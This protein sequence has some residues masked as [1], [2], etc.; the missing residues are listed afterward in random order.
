MMKENTKDTVDQ[1]TPPVEHVTEEVNDEQ[2]VEVREE[3]EENASTSPVR[4]A[5]SV[6]SV[7]TKKASYTSS[8]TKDN[9]NNALPMI[10]RLMPLKVLGFLLLLSLVFIIRH[11]VDFNRYQGIDPSDQK[12]AV[13]EF[14]L[15]Q[16]AEEA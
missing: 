13:A 8:T 12:I 4:G 15:L 16:L 7:D 11:M 1:E 10:Y 2:H 3:I 6:A 5:G 14:E 9:N